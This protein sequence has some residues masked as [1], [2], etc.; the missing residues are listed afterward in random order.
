MIFKKDG[1][2]YIKTPSDSIRDQ[3]K[4]K[5]SASGAQQM[6]LTVTKAQWKDL[7]KVLDLSEPQIKLETWWSIAI[8]YVQHIWHDGYMEQQLQK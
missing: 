5:S 8:I 1:I 7:V 6:I 3:R 2:P 4:S